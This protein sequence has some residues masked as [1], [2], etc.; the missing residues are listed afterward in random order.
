MKDESK[1][2]ISQQPEY[3]GLKYKTRGNAS[4]Q[5]RP[6]VYFC[7]YEKDFQ[8]LFG[9]VTDE[10]LEVQKNAAFWYYDP[11]EGIPEG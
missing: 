10:I 4:P 8:R 7:C 5:G 2:N 9:P 1:N 3:T 6:R 11:A